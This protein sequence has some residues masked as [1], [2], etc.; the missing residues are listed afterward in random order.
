MRS[1]RPPIALDC[2]DADGV[3]PPGLV[4]PGLAW[5]GCRLRPWH[6]T[7]P[8]MALGRACHR[9]ARRRLVWPGCRLRRC[10]PAAWLSAARCMPPVAS[11]SVLVSPVAG[12]VRWIG[13]RCLL[14]GVAS[15][16]V[17]SQRRRPLPF[18][19]GQVGCENMVMEQAATIAAKQRRPNHPNHLKA[20]GRARVASMHDSYLSI[21]IAAPASVARLFASIRCTAARRNMRRAASLCSRSSAERSRPRA[22]PAAVAAHRV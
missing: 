2:E 4:W 8:C 19:C 1:D 20:S 13:F 7:G 21:S 11:A 12:I 9:A 15:L 3:A 16:H 5:S 14:R 6:G 22:H 18:G 10:V 17:V